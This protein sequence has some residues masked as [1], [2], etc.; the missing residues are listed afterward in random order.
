M[1]GN[2]RN[3]DAG[4]SC[5][6]LDQR[7]RPTTSTFSAFG[8]SAARTAT[9]NHAS[10]GKPLISYAEDGAV[11]GS[12]NGSRI[13][14]SIDL[15]GRTLT[16]TD[17]WGSVA[18]TSYEALTGRVTQSSVA[19]P[20]AQVKAHQ[21]SYS[22]DGQLTQMREGG[23]PI[24]DLTYTNG[25]LVSVVNPTGTGKL[26]NGSSLSAITRDA[27]GATTGITWSFTSSPALSNTVV[28]SQS[29][30][31]VKDTITCGGSSWSSSYTYD[32]V[33]RSVAVSIP[34]H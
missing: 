27:R 22:L 34:R 29:G 14:T 18:T 31:I 6:S 21:F 16:H 7:G 5:T 23:K 28:R 15:L 8:T 3:G 19:S 25:E 26:G 20:T 32:P 1:Q 12:P 24:A 2:G 10:G 11:A 13:T 4:W 9:Y 30:R 33:G 17:V